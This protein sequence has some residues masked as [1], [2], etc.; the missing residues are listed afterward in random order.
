MKKF[1]PVVCSMAMCLIA[2]IMAQSAFG[3]I[4]FDNASSANTNFDHTIGGGANRMLVVGV[5]VEL[6]GDVTI[7]YGGVAMIR[8]PGAEVR[9]VLGDFPLWNDLFYLDESGLPAAGTHQVAWTGA[10]GADDI[11][12][13]AI[14]LANVKQ[15]PPEATAAD[16]DFD[17]TGV[18]F[19][20]VPITTVSDGAMLVDL[21]SSGFGGPDQTGEERDPTIQTER[22]T[23]DGIGGASLGMVM[24]TLSVPTAGGVTPG[25]VISGGLPR[26][27][28][29][30]VAAFA[31]GPTPPPAMSLSPSAPFAI[32]GAD[33]SLSL[34]GVASI[35]GAAWTK[36]GSPLPKAVTA[37]G[38][39]TDTSVTFSPLEFSDTGTYCVTGSTTVGPDVFAVDECFTIAGILPSGTTLPVGTLFGLTVLSVLMACAGLQMLRR[40]QLT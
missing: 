10:A 39:P 40:S 31:A 38:G 22:T 23:V 32:E 21:F 30:S 35:T 12:L 16:G 3:D 1:M 37:G 26:R 29:L 34:S 4:V 17:S 15:G 19:L 13:G 7:T 24:S 25:Y 36:G 20:D 9:I 11:T 8:I 18:Q 5:A 27:I 28:A 14:S 2:L 6:G 33:Y